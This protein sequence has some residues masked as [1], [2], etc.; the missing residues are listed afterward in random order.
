[1]TIAASAAYKGG[2]MEN[3]WGLTKALSIV[4]AAL[5]AGMAVPTASAG[6][7]VRVRL[8][9]LPLP[10]S[11]I[12]S[13]VKS[14][15]LQPDSGPSTTNPAKRG[16]VLTPTHWEGGGTSAQWWGR[17]NGYVLDYGNG[18]SGG[19]GVTE[20]FT[21]VDEYKTSADA[22]RI[23]RVLKLADL[24][25]GRYDR[26]GLSV[27][28][29]LE[30]PARG[31]TRF[32]FL[33]SYRAGNIAPVSGFEE[34]F[35]EGRYE[36]DVIVWAGT[37]TE[38]QRLAKRLAMRLDVRIKLALEGRL[39]ARPVKL[40]VKQKVGPPPGG[41]NLSALALQTSDLNGPAT[42]TESH[43]RL[44]TLNPTVLSDFHVAMSPAGQFDLG[45]EQEIEWCPSANQ[46]N[47]TA[48]IY[49]AE[50]GSVSGLDLASV[51]DGA[52]G[53]IAHSKSGIDAAELIFSSGKLVE[54]I[55]FGSRSG[56]QPLDA[57]DVAQVAANYINAAG[58]GS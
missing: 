34:R 57:Q 40:P 49:A 6:P 33:V 29:R 56:I 13:A 28:H 23:E 39:N 31:S 38:A 16:F 10:A 45:L 48:D 54:T 2:V 55:G 22:R 53:F 44:D 5:I 58:L 51:G 18:A 41:P 14:L 3:R 19:R 12:G 52:R 37:A 15:P 36:A 26:H 50:L 35:T 27:T 32:G 17:I 9:V 25:I 47:F 7:G 30:K 1:M 21:S 24:R 46:A 42:L 8:S 43:Y 11:S 20:V 4:V